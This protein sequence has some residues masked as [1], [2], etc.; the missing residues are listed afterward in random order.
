MVFNCVSCDFCCSLHEDEEKKIMLFPEEVDFL[1]KMAIK[2]DL[3]NFAVIEDLVFP[4]VS[5]KQIL[6]GAYRMLFRDDKTC[7]FFNKKTKH[8]LI[9]EEE[10]F[11]K[12]PLVCRAYP[13]AIKTIDAT[14]KEYYLD[15]GCIAI[16]KNL[17][18]FSKIKEIK[19]IK[20]VELFLEENFPDEFPAAKK[21]EK[22]LGWISLRI[23]QLEIKKEIELPAGSYTIDDWNKA[24]NEWPRMDLYPKDET[25]R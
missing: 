2:H 7:V 15:T 22:R 12:K 20:E 19:S 9:H 24:L 23:K 17:G 25:D 14:K 16:E 10:G 5:S 8:C 1:E 3:M 11:D 4:D 13:I 21:I 6:V 18:Y